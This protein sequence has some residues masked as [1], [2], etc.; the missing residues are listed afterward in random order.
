M[1]RK[2]ACALVVMAVA[3]GVVSADEFFAKITKVDGNKL[4]YQ[5]YEKGKKVGDPVTVE[6]APGTT[7]AEFKR[8]TGAKKVVAGKAIEG[9]LKNKIFPTAPG[10]K[11]LT[12]AITTSDDT[13]AVKR[14][15]V[16]LKLK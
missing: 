16:V 6:I 1:L 12:A 5:K 11:E 10:D 2:L 14:I 4:T 8:G 7:I 9:G 15:L 3:V 13:K